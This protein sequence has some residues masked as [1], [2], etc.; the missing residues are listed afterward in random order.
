[1]AVRVPVHDPEAVVLAVAR[2]AGG[3]TAEEHAII[4]GA[5][6]ARRATDP[7]S[8]VAASTVQWAGLVLASLRHRRCPWCGGSVREHS[9]DLAPE[10]CFLAC[11]AGDRLLRADLWL[12]GPAA[13]SNGYVL[14]SLAG[15]LA[16]P[17]L[18]FGLLAWVMPFV[19]AI[20]R[21]R[22]SW[23][24]A[25]SVL[26]LLA[27]LGAALPDAAGGAFLLLAWLGGTGYGA[28]QVQPWLRTRPLAPRPTP[29]RQHYPP[30]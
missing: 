26:L 4:Y 6:I 23:A 9:L 3:V 10:G 11:H 15:W 30:G 14:A 12:P 27:A 20:A 5:A 29:T 13:M 24:V 18:T 16:L 21:H 8:S 1:M 17:L 25:A 7:D 28:L 2:A 19:A 22:R